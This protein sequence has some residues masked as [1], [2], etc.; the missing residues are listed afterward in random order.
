M[1][2]GS[3]NYAYFRI[4]ELSDEIRLQGGCKDF[5]ASAELRQQFKDHLCL[6]AKACRAIEWNDSFDGDREEVE[7]I[8][9]CLG[10]KDE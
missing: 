9:K 5:C 6:V 3:Y 2:G 1:S 8:K 10:I 7:L 4:E